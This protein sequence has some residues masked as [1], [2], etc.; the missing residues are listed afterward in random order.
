MFTDVI[1]FID[2]TILS[3]FLSV[4][5]YLSMDLVLVVELF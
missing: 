1:I 4:E 2:G 5:L 3:L